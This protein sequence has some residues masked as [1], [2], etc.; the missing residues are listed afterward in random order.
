MEI[1]S[2][3]V[4]VPTKGCVCKCKTCVSRIHGQETHYQ[5]SI[6]QMVDGSSWQFKEEYR[7]RLEFARDNG[8][9]TMVITGAPGEPL[10]NIPFLEKL[11][12]WN[13]TLRKPF[14]WIELQTT[15]VML[16]AE[17]LTKLRNWG[18]STISLSTFDIFDSA[19]NFDIIGASPALQYNIEG[20]CKMI[21]DMGFN[22]R[23][24]VNLMKHYNKLMIGETFTRL[25]ELGAD[26][27][28]FRKLYT[29]DIK[30]PINDYIRENSMNA[31]IIK[32]L[33]E[34]IKD[35]GTPLEL[36]PLGARKYSYMGISTVLDD[37]CMSKEENQVIR[38]LILRENC[39][40]YTKWDDKASLLF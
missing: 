28:T 40:L 2:L 4:V 26:Q 21:K 15:G 35:Y 16:T 25:V 32:N 29:S 37:D 24:C 9:N 11:F 18:V 8:C 34:Y 3:S 20:R 36:L 39:K 33:N 6:E 12:A 19:N 5:N 17:N 7:R 27:V 23:I 13:Q 10:Q 22:L 31:V 30:S 14:Y 1:Q 38:Y